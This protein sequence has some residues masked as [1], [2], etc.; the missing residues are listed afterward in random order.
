MH[1]NKNVI[2]ALCA[3]CFTGIAVSIVLAETLSGVSSE[4]TA[5]L[6]SLSELRLA[7]YEAETA[8]PDDAYAI[9]DGGEY[10]Y[11]VLSVDE[12]VTLLLSLLRD[13]GGESKTCLT[14]WIYMDHESGELVFLD[15]CGWEVLRFTD[16]EGA[17]P[18]MP[19]W[20]AD[21]SG[22]IILS[23]SIVIPS[24]N[25]VTSSSASEASCPGD[26]LQ[27]QR[28]T[29]S[30]MTAQSS[31]SQVARSA[32][33]QGSS[34]SD[35]Q[36]A[37][38]ENVHVQN[39]A[40]GGCIYVDRVKGSD[41]LTGHHPRSRGNFSFDGPKRTIHGGLAAACDGDEVRIAT[42]TYNEGIN[43]SGRQMT[44]RVDGVVR[45]AKRQ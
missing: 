2:C 7:V 20:P 21:L 42:G 15:D 17:I 41:L 28:S 33:M 14:A 29:A 31:T 23:I 34:G 1:N 32:S 37:L 44:V 36:A 11:D 13:F 3:M 25:T 43:V 5:A 19:A 27:H 6:S 40:R 4:S 18:V 30:D 22:R 35:G 10:T 26:S 9:I 8:E 16:E 39:N 24:T 38:L 12:D 45:L